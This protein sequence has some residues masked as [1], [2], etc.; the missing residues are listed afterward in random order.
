MAWALDKSFYLAGK[1][2]SHKLP[3]KAL[4]VFTGL[5][6]DSLSTCLR[7]LV[8]FSAAAGLDFTT[9]ILPFTHPHKSGNQHPTGSA[10]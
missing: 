7:K 9:L 10:N 8:Q 6:K 2:S 4:R 1:P 3:C 5:A